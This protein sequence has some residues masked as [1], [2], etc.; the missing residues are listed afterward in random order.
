MYFSQSNYYSYM[1]KFLASVILLALPMLVSAQVDAFTTSKGILEIKPVH[2]GSFWM[3][4]NNLVIAVDPYGG[5]NRYEAMGAPNLILI[6]DI[7]GDHLD[8]STLIKLNLTKA[9]IVAPAAVQEKLKT[10]LPAETKIQVLA[11]NDSVE[12]A[13][14][15]VKAIPMYNLTDSA[16]ARHPKGRGNGYVV[17]LGGKRV[18][19]SGD[20]DDIP[21]M[22]S[23]QRIDIAFVCMNP[24]YTMDIN[25]AASAVL[26]FKPAV[27]FPYHFRQ[28]Q[29]FSDVKAFLNL[30]KTGNPE[31]DV[32]LR[33]W[34]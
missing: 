25:K 6:T 22:R 1:N 23:L 33:E 11:N 21:E 28:P 34:Y 14:V 18:Y 27:V 7:H 30:V 13:G 24:P 31:I 8:S 16:S 12:L 20:T 29:G 10:F 15:H 2:H 4:W 17:R 3:R 9:T 26:A 5:A 19:I 32:R